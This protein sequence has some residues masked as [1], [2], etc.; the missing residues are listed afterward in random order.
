M[1]WSW[2][3]CLWTWYVSLFRVDLGL[4]KIFEFVGCLSILH[5]YFWYY[6]NSLQRRGDAWIVASYESGAPAD[7]N[8]GLSAWLL[9]LIVISRNLSHILAAECRKVLSKILILAFGVYMYKQAWQ[10]SLSH[11]IA[12]YAAVVTCSDYW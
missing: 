3:E 2:F 11:S 7:H 1:W 6:F 5:S 9:V 4:K 12:C 10:Y 8:R